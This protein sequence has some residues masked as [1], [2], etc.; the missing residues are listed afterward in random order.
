MTNTLQARPSG[1]FTT[2]RS[3]TIAALTDA[4]SYEGEAEVIS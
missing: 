4:K 1:G 2:T 3:L